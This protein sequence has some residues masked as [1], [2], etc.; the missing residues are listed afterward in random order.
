MTE[1]QKPTGR[2]ERT[3]VEAWPDADLEIRT[4]G[5]GMTFTGYAAVFNQWSQDMGFREKIAPG[6][7]SKTLGEK[8]R[9]IRMFLN[10]NVDQVLATTKAETLSL[11]ED[12]KGLRVEAKLPDTG[13][14]RDLAYLMK[15]GDVDS[16]S[17]GFQTVRDEWSSD[18]TTRTLLEVRLFEVSPV[19]GWPAYTGTSA[20]VR[21]L[22]EAIE[23][24][25]E[26]LDAALRVFVSEKDELTPEQHELLI[27]A[28]N[29]RTAKELQ[30][31]GPSLADYRARFAAKGFEV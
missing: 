8:R 10:H 18:L 16:M 26:T 11:V 25:S 3:A 7:F 24:D 30:F 14:G 6:A 4:E 9:D 13:A 20:A 15:R 22:A 23:T 21:T 12:Q 28:L 5:D 31:V 27:R 1:F 29:A 17:F 2:E 19:T